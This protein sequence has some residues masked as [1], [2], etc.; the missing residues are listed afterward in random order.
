MKTDDSHT[1][2]SYKS[3]ASRNCLAAVHSTPHEKQEA[4]PIKAPR[5]ASV[6]QSPNPERTPERLQDEVMIGFAL[7][8]QIANMSV[9][10]MLAKHRHGDVH[11]RA[12]WIDTRTDVLANIVVLASGAVVALTGFGMPT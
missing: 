6:R 8:L 9:L 11:M 12:T 7:L 4:L 1:A 3:A 2:Q 5:N 10:R